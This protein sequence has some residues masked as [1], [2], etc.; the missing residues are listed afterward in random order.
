MDLEERKDN[1]SNME[2][3]QNTISKA[4][5]ASQIA[6]GTLVQLATQRQQLLRIDDDLFTINQTLAQCE[7]RIKGVNLLHVHHQVQPG[8]NTNMFTALFHNS[9]KVP[10]EA[11]TRFKGAPST[12][13]QP[14]SKMPSGT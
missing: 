8:L 7:K 3:L 5:E 6:D 9:A 4:A 1:R 13:T 14:E 2:I 12:F 11:D 10:K